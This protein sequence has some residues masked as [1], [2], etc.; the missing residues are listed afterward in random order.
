M[1]HS[2]AKKLDKIVAKLGSSKHK[3][4]KANG[5]EANEAQA[6]VDDPNATEG[7]TE[8]SHESILQ[9]MKGHLGHMHGSAKVDPQ[10]SVEGAPP[11]HVIANDLKDSS[12]KGKILSFA[13]VR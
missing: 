4:A 6:H 12:F 5:N 1:S 8:S 13:H 10:Q 11:V 3:E 2:L 7:N 9:R